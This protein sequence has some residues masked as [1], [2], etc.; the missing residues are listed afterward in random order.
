[1]VD[2]PIR[3]YPDPEELDPKKAKKGA[4]PKKKKK[5]DNFPTPEWAEELSAVQE[6]VKE[7]QELAADKVN[8]KLDDTFLADF[9]D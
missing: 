7:M 9:K 2:Y 6:K 5:K 4:P 3:E 8:L 1:M